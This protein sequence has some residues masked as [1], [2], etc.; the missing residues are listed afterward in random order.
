VNDQ[1]PGVVEQS[2]ST[3]AVTEPAMDAGAAARNQQ[4]SAQLAGLYRVIGNGA[5]W[6]YWVAGLSMIN[7]LIALFNGKVSFMFGL[8]VTQIADASI[9]EF[10]P[11][12]AI[13]ALPVNLFIAG[14]YVLFGYCAGRRMRWA[15]Y[16]GLFFY[17]LD[18][19]LLVLVRE[20]LS[21]AFHAWV[22]FA[23]YR[24]IKADDSAR[25]LEAQIQP[26]PV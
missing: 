10:G 12:A 2:Q 19:L 21:V 24:G 20:W 14:V 22:V 4:I 18:A 6:F 5:N 17:L 15:F 23:I 8:G 25:Q 9:Q 1:E 7:T 26:Q 3:S 11:R 16:T 13:I